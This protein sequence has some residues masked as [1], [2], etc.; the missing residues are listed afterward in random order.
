MGYD[1][2]KLAPGE[3]RD[4]LTTKEYKQIIA[5]LDLGSPIELQKR[6]YIHLGK[7]TYF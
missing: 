1:K 2:Q 6:V 4:R 3:T 7:L 5:L